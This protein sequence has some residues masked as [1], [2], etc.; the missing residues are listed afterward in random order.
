LGSNVGQARGSGVWEKV[1][2]T[3]PMAYLPNNP[4]FAENIQ[5]IIHLF[6]KKQQGAPTLAGRGTGVDDNRELYDQWAAKYETD[7][8]SWGYV[9]PEKVAAL[10]KKHAAPGS[11]AGLAVFDAGAGDGLSGQALLDAGFKDVVG[12]DLSP[13]LVAL[14]EKRGCYKE[15]IV[16]D[17]SKKLTYDNDRFDLITCVGVL[18]YL[19]PDCGVLEE[20]CRVTKPD[21]LVCFTNRTDKADA[22]APTLAKLETAGMWEK[23]VITE[24]MA[25]LP[26][27]P[28]I[29]ENIQVIIHLFRKKQPSGGGC[30]TM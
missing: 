2:I 16:A 21:G 12:S 18:T 8:R 23:V 13:E 30:N 29:A 7:V 6:R 25:Y 3:E 17:L 10:V 11:E 1:V 15:I 27:N 4:E 20:F 22:W 24:P 9:M 26:N 28:E 5:V 14:A 19:Q